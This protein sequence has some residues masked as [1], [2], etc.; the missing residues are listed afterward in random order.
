MKFTDL[1]TILPYYC[2]SVFADKY[3]KLGIELDA[4]FFLIL[5]D[6]L[7][8]FSFLRRC[9]IGHDY[10]FYLSVINFQRYFAKYFSMHKAKRSL[11]LP[12]PRL[13]A[14][15]SIMMWLIYL[16]F[17]VFEKIKSL[18]IHLWMHPKCVQLRAGALR[19]V[20][21]YNTTAYIVQ[22]GSLSTR[23]FETRTATGSEL[24]SLLT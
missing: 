19:G 2:Y 15:G 11:I 24:F 13:I 1:N 7:S 18:V 6:V 12:F 23:V 16:S 5:T 20:D 14:D 22:L 3:T 8:A 17:I 10:R 9:K 21:H 4:V